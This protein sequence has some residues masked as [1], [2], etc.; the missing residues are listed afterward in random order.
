MSGQLM[1][2]Y[3]AIFAVAGSL[4]K[5]NARASALS[6]F[7][8]NLK[9]QDVGPIMTLEQ[10]RAELREVS[11]K[12]NRMQKQMN[13]LSTVLKEELRLFQKNVY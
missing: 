6:H 11:C 9:E 10:L 13:F 4:N 2:T 3:E 5:L 7:I 1:L 8:K 12:L